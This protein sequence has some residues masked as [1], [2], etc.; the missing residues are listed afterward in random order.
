MDTQLVKFKTQLSWKNF[1]KYVIEGIAVAVAAYLIPKRKT[2]IEEIAIIASVASISFF[3]LDVF[4][5][6]VITR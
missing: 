2:S 1:V 3:I 4:S 6:D 5:E